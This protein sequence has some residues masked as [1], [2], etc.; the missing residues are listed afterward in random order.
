M[1]HLKI[2]SCLCTNPLPVKHPRWW[3]RK[4]YLLSSVPVP[5]VSLWNLG[6]YQFWKELQWH[7]AITNPAITKPCYKEQHKLWNPGKIT[8]CENEPSY[9]E[10]GYNEIP[11][12]TNRFWRSQPTI[13]PTTT[14]NLSAHRKIGKM[15]TEWHW[16]FP[17]SLIESVLE[18]YALIASALHSTVKLYFQ[19]I[20]SK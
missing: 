9:I 19:N 8:V 3:Y 17:T 7:R 11:A 6:L 10:P 4:A 2:T 20:C 12:I 18:I 15:I 1:G 13:N 14:N 5:P 16:W